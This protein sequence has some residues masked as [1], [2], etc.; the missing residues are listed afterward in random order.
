MTHDASFQDVKMLNCTITS[1]IHFRWKSNKQA[2]PTGDYLVRV[3]EMH[4][5]GLCIA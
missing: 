1:K 4:S 2:V 5:C 3:N